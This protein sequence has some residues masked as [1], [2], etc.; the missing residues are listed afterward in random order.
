MCILRAISFN[1]SRDLQSVDTQYP[2]VRHEKYPTRR[3]ETICSDFGTGDFQGGQ[4]IHLRIM[5]LDP[6]DRP[7][8]AEFLQ[9]QWFDLQMNGL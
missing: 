4:G 9:D 8:A 2:G 1:L 3:K 5:K 6:R 7:S